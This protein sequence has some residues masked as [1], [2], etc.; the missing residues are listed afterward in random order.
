VISQRLIDEYHRREFGEEMARVNA[1][2]KAERWA[3]VRQLWER[4]RIA[5]ER[6]SIKRPHGPER[7]WG[8]T[9]PSESSQG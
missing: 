2:P 7:I 1:L 8:E 9:E 3:Y 6:D 5:E 4:A